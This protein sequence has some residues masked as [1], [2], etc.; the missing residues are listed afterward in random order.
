MNTVYP[1]K[2][3]PVLFVSV[4]LWLYNQ[5]LNELMQLHGVK[6]SLHKIPYFP[7]TISYFPLITIVLPMFC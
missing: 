3:A 1:I 7:L 6:P 2:Y 5:F 4:L